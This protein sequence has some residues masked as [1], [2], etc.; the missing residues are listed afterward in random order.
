MSAGVPCPYVPGKFLRTV[1]D[2]LHSMSHPSIRATQQLLTA[3]Y[4]TK[5]FASGHR[6]VYSVRDAKYV[7]Q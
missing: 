4:V 7:T 2:C 1:F 5:M 6:L 3:R